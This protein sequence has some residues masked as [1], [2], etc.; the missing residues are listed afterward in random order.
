MCRTGL[1]REEPVQTLEERMPALVG[2][3]AVLTHIG[4]LY[5]SR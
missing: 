5:L 1:R 4:D 2:S 3:L